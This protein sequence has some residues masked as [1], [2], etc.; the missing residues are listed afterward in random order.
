MHLSFGNVSF[1]YD[2]YPIGLATR[3]LP[4]GTYTPVPPLRGRPTHGPG[5]P[6]MRKTLTVVIVRGE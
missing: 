3:V 5:G 1:R 6:A 4:H 2:P